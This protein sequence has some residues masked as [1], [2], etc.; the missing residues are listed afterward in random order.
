[1]IKANA[2]LKGGSLRSLDTT[3]RAEEASVLIMSNAKGQTV[4][5]VNLIDKTATSA[6]GAK[7]SSLRN[8]NP[9]AFAAFERWV[10]TN[11]IEYR[12]NN[13]MATRRQKR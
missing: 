6:Q 7:A 9:E 5:L 1:M 12:R 8:S 11:G 10:E 13:R 3:A 2:E 4:G